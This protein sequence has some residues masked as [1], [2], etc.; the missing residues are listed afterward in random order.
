MIVTGRVVGIEITESKADYHQGI[1][2]R[3][4]GRSFSHGV[5]HVRNGF[6]GQFDFTP[7]RITLLVKI[8]NITEKVWVDSE[9]RHEIGN[10]TK[11]R[12]QA[13]CE[14]APREVDLYENKTQGG[15]KF[16]CLTKSTFAKWLHDSGL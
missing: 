9:F 3:R 6:G 10:L 5:V 14:A 12:T 15:E 16:Y 8:G 1:K 2:G 4:S 7:K 13:I 11:K